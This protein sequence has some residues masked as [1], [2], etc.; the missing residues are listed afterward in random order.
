MNFGLFSAGESDF[1]KYILKFKNYNT[2]GDEVQK[3]IFKL[4]SRG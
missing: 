4:E 1:E 3:Y 2:E